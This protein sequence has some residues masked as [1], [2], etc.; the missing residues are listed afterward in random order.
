[1]GGEEEGRRRR[2][3]GGCGRQ[4]GEAGGGSRQNL[5]RGTSCE[6]WLSQKGERMAS[7][8]CETRSSDVFLFNVVFVRF[9]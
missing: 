5:E 9:V 2:N 6:G 7:A 1:M 8:I 4:V 3:W